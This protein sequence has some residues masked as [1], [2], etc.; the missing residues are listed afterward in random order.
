MPEFTSYPAGTPSW[1]DLASPDLAAS[2]AF[3][4]ALFGWEPDDQGPDAGHYTMLRK[5]GKA[6][7]GAGPIMMEG[8]PPAWTTY[9]AV[10][11]ADETVDLAKKAGAAVFVEPMDVMDVGRMAIFADPTGAAL[12]IWQAKNFKGAELANEPGSFVWNELQTR[13]LPAAKEFY[14]SVFGWQPNDMEMG[15]MSYTE[16]KKGDASVAGMMAMPA[17]VPSEVPSYWL[18]YFGVDDTDATVSKA[19]G[20]GAGALVPPTD[21]PPGRFAVL[22]DPSG[23][24][25]AVIKTKTA[26]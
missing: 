2:N 15:E 14:T 10:D 18:V 24:T 3:Y 9:V 6:V 5:Q 22:M 17:E 4:G 25:F 7:A 23:A 8:Q 12:G 19:T 16:W 11:D 1:T 13:D 26:G 20:L 21:I